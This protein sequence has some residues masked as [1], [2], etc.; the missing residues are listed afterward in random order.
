[1]AAHL[2]GTTIA[3]FLTHHW[4]G[5][6][7][8]ISDP[9]KEYLSYSWH[10]DKWAEQHKF[11][12]KW[13]PRSRN[14]TWVAAQIREDIGEAWLKMSP[15]FARIYITGCTFGGYEGNTDQGLGDAT[16]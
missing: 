6:Q 16:C 4:R 2:V 1:M 15:N 3:N 8:K 5:T 13:F 12:L 11:S 7:I 9:I 10:E 14:T